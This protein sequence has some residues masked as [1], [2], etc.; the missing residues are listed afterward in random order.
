MNIL[1]FVSLI[2]MFY[3][4]NEWVYKEYKKSIRAGYRDKL[5]NQYKSVF[6]YIW[7]WNIKGLMGKA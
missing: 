6:F 7:I 2:C 5:P 3:I 1:L 4:R